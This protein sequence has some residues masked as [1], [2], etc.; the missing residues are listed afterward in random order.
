[1]EPVLIGAMCFDDP[2]RHRT[3]SRLRLVRSGPQF[4]PRPAQSCCC[5]T[6]QETCSD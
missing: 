4:H 5:H 3:W 6:G 2:D 1:M